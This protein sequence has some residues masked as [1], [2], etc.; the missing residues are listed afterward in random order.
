[1]HLK[2]NIH[3][4]LLNEPM[5]KLYEL[6]KKTCFVKKIV[7]VYFLGSLYIKSL[8]F[9]IMCVYYS[10]HLLNTVEYLS[11]KRLGLIYTFLGFIQVSYSHPTAREPLHPSCFN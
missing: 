11:K 8:F 5:N 4:Q 7:F 6:Q 1:M 9:P 10:L 3:Y 2:L